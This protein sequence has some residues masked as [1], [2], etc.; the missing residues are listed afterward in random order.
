MNAN[1]VLE[2]E[3]QITIENLETL[4]VIAHPV[5]LQ[6]L[7]L[8]NIPKTVKEIAAELST[9]PT[10]LY[11]HVNLLENHSLIQVVETN[12]V[13]GIIEKQYQVSARRY[14]IDDG[15]FADKE[16]LTEE[17]LETIT[18][19]VIEDTKQEMLRSIRSGL[20]DPANNAPESGRLLKGG[21]RLSQEQAAAFGNQFEALC[22]KYETLS[23]ENEVAVGTTDYHYTVTFYPIKKTPG[24][25]DH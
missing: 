4:K 21:F 3:D 24:V 19:A 15:L 14:H 5:R 9:P 7:K 1:T 13:S 23:Q 12:I 10:K 18:V 20:M 25:E 8:L 11:Y 22:Q 16:P 17:T 2:I 6:I